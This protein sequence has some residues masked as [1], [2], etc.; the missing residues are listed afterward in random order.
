MILE[1]FDSG[2][3]LT[4]VVV[5]ILALALVISIFGIKGCIIDEAN[6]YLKAG[7]EKVYILGRTEPVW[8]NCKKPLEKSQ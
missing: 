4:I 1:K 7:C 3:M 8:G 5:I 2:E 6:L